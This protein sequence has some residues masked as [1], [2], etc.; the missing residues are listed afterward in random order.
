MK[1]AFG[2]LLRL[3][4]FLLALAVLCAGILAL[5]AVEPARSFLA[6]LTGSEGYDRSATLEIEP[7]IQAVQQQDS[8]T[9]LIV[10]D[11]VCAQVFNP[12]Y[13]C[14]SDYSIQGSNR[15]IT[16]AG[17]YLLIEQ[18][19]TFHPNAQQVYLVA[20]PELFASSFDTD[21][22]YQ[23]AVVPFAEAGLLSH[24]DAQTHT[25]ME[26][27]YG[28]LFLRVRTATWV[29]WSPL[30]K[31]LYLN[32]L[33]AVS[34]PEN[35][36]TLNALSLRMLRAMETLCT[37]HG[38]TFT[39][40]PA[41]LADSESRRAASQALKDAFSADGLAED[42][43]VAAYFDAVHLSP[44]SDFGEDGIHF[45]PAKCDIDYYT[46]VLNEIKTRTGLLDGLV[47]HYDS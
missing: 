15:A 12:F 21:Y 38:V 37:I 40:L 20:G 9:K 17:Q 22:G 2:F 31:K 4:A 10:G 14:N 32:G 42:P 29:D 26:S 19:L 25:E 30:G 35:G 46:S 3:I 33:K 5:S 39:L 47:T 34:S 6:A 8:T 36:G 18:Y 43:V 1:Q 16:M 44:A 11:S 24:L 13:L 7:H 28:G 45:D 27:V 23:Y 41:P